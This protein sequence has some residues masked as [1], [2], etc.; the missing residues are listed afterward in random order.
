MAG[1]RVDKRVERGQHSRRAILD[2]AMDIAS[3]EGLE[4]LSVRR[5]AAELELSKSGVF[6]QFGS[7]EELQLATVRAAVEVYVDKVVRPARRA[8]AGIRRV[9]ALCECWLA[10]ATEPVFPGG[11]F[12]LSVAAEFDARP[13]RVRDAVAAARRDWQRLYERTIHEARELGEITPETDAAQLAFELDALARGGGQD[14]LLHDDPKL[15]DRV[16]TALLVRLRSVA[17][18]SAL[19]D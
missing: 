11:C 18:D 6:A 5:L 10:Y 3:V 13:G 2:R 9:R 14:A 15:Y 1:P 17:T 7:K 19:L 16:R 4:S 8:P 12:F